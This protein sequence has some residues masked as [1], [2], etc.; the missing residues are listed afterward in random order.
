MEMRAAKP[1]VAHTLA[2]K[3]RPCA[4]VQDGER[5]LHVLAQIESGMRAQAVQFDRRAF[6]VM[7]TEILETR[8][9]RAATRLARHTNQC[10]LDTSLVICASRFGL[11]QLSG[12]Q[13]YGP[14][15]RLEAPIAAFLGSAALQREALTRLFA[16]KGIDYSPAALAVRASLERFAITFRGSILYADQLRRALEAFGVLPASSSLSLAPFPLEEAQP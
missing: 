14:E 6:N 1:V 3:F 5:V 16:A 13:L 2:P 10:D 8:R 15:I 7:S 4:P 9:P 11:F 12:A